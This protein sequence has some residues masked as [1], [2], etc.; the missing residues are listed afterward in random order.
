MRCGGL[1][2][3]PF[4]GELGVPG[5]GRPWGARRQEKALG[6]QVLAQDL[7]D[8]LRPLDAREVVGQKAVGE[9]LQLQVHRCELDVDRQVVARR[10]QEALLAQHQADF[11]ELRAP[12]LLDPLVDD[13]RRQLARLHLAK[14][15]DVHP[16]VEQ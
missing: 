8:P 12:D 5:L 16:G 13:S 15:G 3:V 1:P 10:E 9:I 4:P 6:I 7:V 14:H 11:L 2:L